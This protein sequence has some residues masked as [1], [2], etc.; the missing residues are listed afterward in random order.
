MS[1]PI[2]TMYCTLLHVPVCAEA[3]IGAVGWEIQIFLTSS[4]SF[5]SSLTDKQHSQSKPTRL[6]PV[7][8][9]IQSLL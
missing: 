2:A 8:I 4:H 6:L 7:K 9:I 3:V 1:Y 5:P